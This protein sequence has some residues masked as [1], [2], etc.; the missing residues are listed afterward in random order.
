MTRRNGFGFFAKYC[1]PHFRYFVHW[2]HRIVLKLPILNKQVN[3]WIYLLP[4]STKLADY[5]IDRV[6]VCLSV[7]QQDY[8]KSNQSISLKLGVMIGPTTGKNR[9]TVGVNPIPDT[10]SGS[11]FHFPQHCRLRHFSRFIIISLTV[12]GRFSRNSAKCWR[13]R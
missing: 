2:Q 4:P 11:L 6:C 7:C 5:V 3:K 10:D 9:L 8:C 1:A 13:R 12:T